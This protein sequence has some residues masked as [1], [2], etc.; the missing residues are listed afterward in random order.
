MAIV[1]DASVTLSWL[2]PDET[3][4]YADNVQDRLDDEDAVVP[5]LWPLE[6]ANGI[7]MAERSKRL[8]EAEVIRILDQLS[9]FNILIEE[10][11]S[12]AEISRILNV[13]RIEKLTAYDAAYLDLAMREGLPLATLDEG[14]R[15]AAVRVGVPLVA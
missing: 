2:F 9:S 13:A 1:I 3:S 14:L 12:T 7:L 8:S 15:A 6:V 5:S 4:N 11:V 10:S